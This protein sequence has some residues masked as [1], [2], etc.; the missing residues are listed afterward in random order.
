MTLNHV[1]YK[2]PS[3]S[4]TGGNDLLWILSDFKC[5]KGDDL[6]FYGPDDV[7]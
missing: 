4:H 3:T 7:S 2:C 6:L 1:L 5:L